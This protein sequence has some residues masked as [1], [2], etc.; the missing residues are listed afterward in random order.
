MKQ[1]YIAKFF[2]F[3]LLYFYKNINKEYVLGVLL[4]FYVLTEFVNVL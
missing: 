4:L 3:F 2:C 1:E